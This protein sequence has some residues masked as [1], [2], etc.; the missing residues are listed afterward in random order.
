[1]SWF[2]EHPEMMREL[3]A[4]NRSRNKIT[5]LTTESWLHG[6]EDRAC[7]CVC[8]F[9]C[10]CMWAWWLL[11][12]VTSSSPLPPSFL[13]FP[14]GHRTHLALNQV[15]WFQG[16]RGHSVH[17]AY[18]WCKRAWL[19]TE[20]S[21]ARC[22]EV[23]WAFHGWELLEG[24]LWAVLRP[25]IQPLSS[26]HIE[27]RFLGVEITDTLPMRSLLPRNTF[28]TV[29]DNLRP[30]LGP[31][32]GSAWTRQDALGLLCFHNVLDVLNILDNKGNLSFFIPPSLSIEPKEIIWHSSIFWMLMT[33]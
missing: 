32:M 16:R 29:W 8:V 33:R 26:P 23:G 11:S 27:H 12:G 31:P 7:V 21:S 22:Y 28:S 15:N 4:I 9:T 24:G 13:D 20:N 18:E 6:E 30:Q 17:A 5:K 14:L 19:S 10:M 1:M 2:M 3:W 25:P